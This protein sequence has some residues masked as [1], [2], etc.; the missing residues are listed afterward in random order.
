MYLLF[1]YTGPAFSSVYSSALLFRTCF[2]SFS[3][4]INV[5]ADGF[6]LSSYRILELFFLKQ[7][8]VWN[9]DSH[10]KP[11]IVLFKS[12]QKNS[13]NETD[14][15]IKNILPALFAFQTFSKA[16]LSHTNNSLDLE[17]ARKKFP[18]LNI[19]DHLK[20]WTCPQKPY[21][22]PIASRSNE[23]NE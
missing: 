6:Q 13:F 8:F 14:C 2:R 19:S 9:V 1:I 22:S 12:D 23:K 4:T 7:S 20:V 3:E 16:E 11:D 15:S 10:T 18:F 5:L 21:H 17:L